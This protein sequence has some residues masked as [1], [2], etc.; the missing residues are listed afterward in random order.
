MGRD[1]RL[2]SLGLLIHELTIHA[3]GYALD[4]PCDVALRRFQGVNELEHQI[5]GQISAYAAGRDR[6]SDETFWR[7]LLDPVWTLRQLFPLG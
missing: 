1:Q 3:R 4:F 7:S 2:E 6:Y 5:S